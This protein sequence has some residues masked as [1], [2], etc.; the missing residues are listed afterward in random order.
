[1][2]DNV[3]P[4]P[5]GCHTVTPYLTVSDAARALEFYQ[6]A[7]GAEELLRLHTKNGRIVHAEMSL[8]DSRL[9]LA[10]E[11]SSGDTRSPNALNGSTASVFLYVEDVDSAFARATDAGARAD[12]PPQDMYWGDRFCKLTDPFGHKWMMSSH[13][14]DVPQE[15]IA[16]RASTQVV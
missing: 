1:M 8:G 6:R 9:M 16:R 7:F 4:V 12:M 5:V 13:V 10:E 11:S 2:K 3:R 15:E 14:E